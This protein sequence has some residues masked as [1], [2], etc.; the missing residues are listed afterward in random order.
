MTPQ[1]IGDQALL[2][3]AQPSVSAGGT[4]EL[5]TETIQGSSAS[6]I[7]ANFT[8]VD[9]ADVSCFVISFQGTDGNTGQGSLLRIGT[10]S[11]VIGLG[12]VSEEKYNTQAVYVGDSSHFT[13]IGYTQETSSGKWR[14]NNSWAN[15]SSFPMIYLWGNPVTDNPQMQM[16]VGCEITWAGIGGYLD[17]T[18][19]SL[20]EVI[21]YADGGYNILADS[22]LQIYKVTR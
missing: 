1:D 16:N 21:I 2:G 9:F 11:G 4:W 18:L 8:N 20:G 7:E 5:I 15:A 13:N 17:Y 14:I 22:R 12:G 3:V 10:S 19:T 6:T